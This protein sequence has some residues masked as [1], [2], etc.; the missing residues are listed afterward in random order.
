MPSDTTAALS[1][2]HLT[3]RY[4]TEPVLWDITA[5]IP[6]GTLL[7]VVG[8]NGAGKTTFIKSILNIIK[9]DAGTVSFFGGSYKEHT[10]RIAYVPQRLSVDWDFPAHVLDV[11]LMGRYAHMGWFKRPSSADYDAAWLALEQVQLTNYAYRHI[12]QLSGGQQQ[13]VFLARALVQQADIYLMDEPFMGVDM[14]TEHTIVELLKTLRNQGKTIIVVH[15][16]LQTLQDYFDWLLLLNI[17][18]IACGPINQVLHAENLHATYGKHTLFTT[19]FNKV[20]ELP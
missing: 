7:A 9:P 5:S 20:K 18:L 11:V 3:V 16:D 14:A 17:K 6:H 4:R 10:Q 2:S 15:H 19:C 13:R 12:S 8:P 1:I